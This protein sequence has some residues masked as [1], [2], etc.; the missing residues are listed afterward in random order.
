MLTREMRRE[1][2]RLLAVDHCL[3]WEPL[4][5]A[6]T[7]APALDEDGRIALA[8]ES[9]VGLLDEDLIYFFRCDSVDGTDQ[10]ATDDSA[11]LSTEEVRALLAAREWVVRRPP[12]GVARTVWFELTRKGVDAWDAQKKEEDVEGLENL[13]KREFDCMVDHETNDSVAIRAAS[14]EERETGELAEL[15]FK[16]GAAAIDV[17]CTYFRGIDD[18]DTAWVSVTAATR[19]E[20]F[21]G[22]WHNEHEFVC[23][24]A[25]LA[26]QSTGR[27]QVAWTNHSDGVL[28]VASA[29]T[30]E[31]LVD[32]F[33][34]SA[35]KHEGRRFLITPEGLMWA[36]PTVLG[37][38]T[39]SMSR[40]AAYVREPH[41]S[42]I[43]RSVRAKDETIRQA[44]PH[45]AALGWTN[46]EFQQAEWDDDPQ[47]GKAFY[48]YFFAVPPGGE[49][50]ELTGALGAVD[51][52]AFTPNLR[53]RWTLRGR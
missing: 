44:R 5:I 8:V 23:G 36:L 24:K 33:V 40:V 51:C 50:S 43:R 30:A 18:L 11:R 45:L 47:Q 12:Q 25:R 3:I 16:T 4:G 27:W 21:D 48:I 37:L 35:R 7:V 17:V 15:T 49:P 2:L 42:S 38:K 6:E 1:I 52:I 26:E 14:D 13:V 9:L 19:N 29:A 22:R 32:L 53:R 10:A 46:L 28:I 31:S 20:I 39:A 34:N 41:A